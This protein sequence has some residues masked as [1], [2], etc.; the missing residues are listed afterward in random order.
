MY[1]HK[2]SLQKPNEVENTIIMIH[3]VAR[4]FELTGD[5]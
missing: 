4:D 1:K 5:N 2:Y 3:R